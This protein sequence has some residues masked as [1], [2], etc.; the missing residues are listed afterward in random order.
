MFGAA[1]SFLGGL[2]P[3]VWVVGVTAVLALTNGWTALKVH[4]YVESKYQVLLLNA[5]AR[6]ITQE[7]E[8]LVLDQ[9]TLTAEVSR[10]VQRERNR[11]EQEIKRE[12]TISNS[13][14]AQSL[15]CL[16][17]NELRQ[18]NAENT[19][20]VIFDDTGKLTTV[21]ELQDRISSRQRRDAGESVE[22]QG[23]N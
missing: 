6:V 3:M 14:T 17:D 10:A 19:D 1:L 4:D 8:V 7:K 11:K 9:K 23:S 12:E 22:K 15:V 13:P 20:D 18:W 16:T 5:K 2:S 21:G